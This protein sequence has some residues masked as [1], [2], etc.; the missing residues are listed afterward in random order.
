MVGTLEITLEFRGLQ[1]LA[2]K[3]G[4][5]NNDSDQSHD[6]KTGSAWPSTTRSLELRKSWAAKP[7]LLAGPSGTPW[8]NKAWAGD[9]WSHQLL[10]PLSLM[11]SQQLKASP[12]RAPPMSLLP[13][14][15]VQ[16]PTTRWAMKVQCVPLPHHCFLRRPHP[17]TR[18]PAGEPSFVIM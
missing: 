18:S 5:R 7:S 3:S 16:S 9:L 11:S 13:F 14:C 10:G 6:C 12:V 8:P 2:G 4:D 17:T 1:T 15:P